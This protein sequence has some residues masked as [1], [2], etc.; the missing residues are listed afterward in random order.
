[1]VN[2]EPGK[3]IQGGGKSQKEQ[4]PPI[5]QSIKNV[6][7]H[8]QDKVLRTKGFFGHEPVQSKD[9]NKEYGVA[10]RVEKHRTKI[11]E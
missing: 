11:L 1:M 7:A 2:S 9:H 5:P 10:E 6:T 8:K 3:I 4:K